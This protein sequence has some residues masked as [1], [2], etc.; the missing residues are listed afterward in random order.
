MDSVIRVHFGAVLLLSAEL[1]AP[2][3]GVGVPMLPIGLCGVAAFVYVLIVTRR[4]RQQT[5]YSPVY[6]DCRRT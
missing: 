5:E 6:E 4:A 1:S 3:R 2:W